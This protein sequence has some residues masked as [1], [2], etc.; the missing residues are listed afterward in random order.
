M[1]KV[2][3]AWDYCTTCIRLD[4]G[5]NDQPCSGSGANYECPDGPPCKRYTPEGSA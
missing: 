5:E 3:M 4:D 2:K 1:D